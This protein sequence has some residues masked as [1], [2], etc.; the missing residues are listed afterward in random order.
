LLFAFEIVL[1]GLRT[2]RY[3]Y[4]LTT[5]NQN[6]KQ[7]PKQPAIKRLKRRNRQESVYTVSDGQRIYLGIDGSPEV[8]KE[9]RRA[10]AE[11]NAGL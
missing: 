3:R 4:G 1:K 2:Q 5:Q 9:Y 10:V 11:D 7:S 6:R 8:D